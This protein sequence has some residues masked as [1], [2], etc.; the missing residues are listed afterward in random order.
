MSVTVPMDTRLRHFWSDLYQCQVMVFPTVTSGKW[1]CT[2]ALTIKHGEP[3][4]R[5]YV[6]RRR[7]TEGCAHQWNAAGG[8]YVYC[9]KCGV[10]R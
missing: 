3:V 8:V 5:V 2:E 4:K 1:E 7:R 9:L 10:A 6:G